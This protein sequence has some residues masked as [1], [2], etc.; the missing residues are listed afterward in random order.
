MSL[1]TYILIPKHDI[2]DLKNVMTFIRDEVGPL[3]VKI[4]QEGFKKLAVKVTLKYK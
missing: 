3:A 2:L 1:N 4:S